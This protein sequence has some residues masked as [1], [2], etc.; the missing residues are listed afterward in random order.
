MQF[1]TQESFDAKMTT[2]DPYEQARLP[3]VSSDEVQSLQNQQKPD[4]R[5]RPPTVRRDGHQAPGDLERW[6]P[7]T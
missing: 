2:H 3:G 4:L 5:R 1:H 6:D 7:G